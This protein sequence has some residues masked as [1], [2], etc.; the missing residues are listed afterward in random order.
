VHQFSP[1]GSQLVYSFYFVF[2]TGHRRNHLSRAST[3]ACG[4]ILQAF[5]GEHLFGRDKYI[6][7]TDEELNH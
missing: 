5:G 4:R 6:F 1:L 7:E 3:S 2:S